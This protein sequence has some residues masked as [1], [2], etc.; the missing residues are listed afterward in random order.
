VL[1]ADSTTYATPSIDDYARRAKE[2]VAAW[3]AMNGKQGGDPAGLA[4]AIV[5]L[6]R[7]L[8]TSLALRGRPVND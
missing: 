5:Q 2:T 3:S 7:N 6:A 4:R 8:S 1:T